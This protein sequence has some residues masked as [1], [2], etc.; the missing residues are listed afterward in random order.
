MSTINPFELTLRLPMPPSVNEMYIIRKIK[1]K[2]GRS[3]GFG[4]RKWRDEAIKAVKGQ[5]D[6]A[7]EPIFIAPLHVSIRINL[8][9]ASDLDN[10]IKACLDVIGKAIP[11]M[12]DDRYIDRIVIERD[13]TIEAAVVTIGGDA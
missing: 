12:P 3:L 4:Y 11:S 9:Y 2:T 7:G 6:M 8:N 5:W 13:R 10:R 1:G